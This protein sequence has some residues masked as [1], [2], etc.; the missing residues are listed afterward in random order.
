MPR[1]P[2]YDADGKPVQSEK[3]GKPLRIAASA[4]L[5]RYRPVEQMTWAPG[6]EMLLR[7]RLIAEGGWFP[8]RGVTCFNLYRPPLIGPGEPDE[9]E[10]WL[11]HVHA[12][13]RDD[14]EHIIHW[15]AHRVQRPE[16]LNHALVL[17]ASKEPARILHWNRS[18]ARLARGTGQRRAR[19]RIL[20]SRF[21]AYLKSVILRIS[22]A[23]DLG[24]SDRL[25]FYD[26]M[27]A[28]IAAPPD[29]LRIHEKHVRASNYS[30]N[31]VGVIITTNHKS[32]GIYLPED[33]RRHFIA[34]S[35][36]KR[37]DFPDS[38]WRERWHYYS[39]EGGDCQTTIDKQPVLAQPGESP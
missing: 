2:L 39:E 26:D 25:A 23:R 7:D 28:I 33:D 21:N 4:W 9:A 15:L 34:W 8:R 13:Y 31:V 1:V 27:K 24:E 22:E 12:V 14:A 17:A 6:E 35:P 20:D 16:K 38:Y 18:N 32:D 19:A 37:S 36:R 29:V 30:D 3:T 10:R 11:N 5:D